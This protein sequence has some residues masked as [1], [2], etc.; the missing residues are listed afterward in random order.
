MRGNI[1]YYILFDI[2]D[3]AYFVHLRFVDKFGE[4]I[5]KWI[6]NNVTACLAQF[7]SFIEMSDLIV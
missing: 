5:W 7:Y 3:Y 4:K 1:E 2:Y 6:F